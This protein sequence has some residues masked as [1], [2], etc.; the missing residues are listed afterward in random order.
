VDVPAGRINDM[1]QVFELPQV[2]ARGLRIELPHPAA[3]QVPLVGS[4][5]HFSDTPVS[6]HLPP[7]RLGEHTDAVLGG[8]LGRS[9]GDIA[10][11]RAAG[12]L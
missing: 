7:P 10:V 6:Y 9:A 3:G 2:A 12:V 1:A 11:L 4:P 8:L 5:F